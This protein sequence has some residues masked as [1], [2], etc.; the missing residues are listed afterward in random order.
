MPLLAQ[1]SL[2]YFLGGLLFFIVW[3]NK[4]RYILPYYVFLILAVPYLI[5]ALRKL[6]KK[7]EEIVHF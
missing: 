4:S 7:R 1:L 5:D 3:E 6:F 2:I